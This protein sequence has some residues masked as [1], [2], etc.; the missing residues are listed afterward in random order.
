M[1]NT[2]YRIQDKGYMGYQKNAGYLKEY[3]IQDTG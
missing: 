2:G 1:K 3:R